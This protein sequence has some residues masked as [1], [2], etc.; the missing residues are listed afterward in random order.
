MV[1]VA[2]GQSEH[3]KLIGAWPFVPLFFPV[4]EDDE[5]GEKREGRGM[6]EVAETN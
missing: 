5:Y 1:A 3:R 2:G 4:A 6:L